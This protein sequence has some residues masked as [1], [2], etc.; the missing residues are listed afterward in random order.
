MEYGLGKV[1]IRMRRDGVGYENEKTDLKKLTYSYYCKPRSHPPRNYPDFRGPVT[2]V[3]SLYVL[4]ET[5]VKSSKK[6]KKKHTHSVL[7]KHG[8]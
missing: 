3:Y 1:A 7:K 6:K 4:I 8:R 5:L 2:I